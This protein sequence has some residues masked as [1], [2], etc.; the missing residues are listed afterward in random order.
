LP[1]SARIEV[2][3]WRAEKKTDSPRSS[4]NLL[5]GSWNQAVGY[6]T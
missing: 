4:K 3:L 2:I 5:P 1:K 6:G